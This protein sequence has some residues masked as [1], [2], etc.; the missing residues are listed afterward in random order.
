VRGE[1]RRGLDVG[2]KDYA[3][4]DVQGEW[5]LSTIN[6]R[7]D[8]RPTAPTNFEKA[9]RGNGVKGRANRLVIP[10]EAEGVQHMALQ[11][12]SALVWHEISEI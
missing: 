2:G 11:G 1:D 9:I 5:R 8:V 10:A 7:L 3:L 6:G 4:E 12:S